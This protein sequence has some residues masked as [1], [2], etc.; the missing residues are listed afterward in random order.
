MI[1][2]FEGLCGV[3]KTTLIEEYAKSR[4]DVKIIPQFIEEPDNLF[5]DCVCMLNDELK[6]KLAID[7]R[8]KVVLM[9]RGYL[10]TLIYG[11]IRY[12]L[13]KQQMRFDHITEWLFNNLNSKLVRPDVYI[14][15]D[16]PNKVCM[17]RVYKDNRMLQE[18]YWYKDLDSVRLWY[19]KLFKTLESGVPLY[20]LNGEHKISSNIK[21]LDKIIHENSI[22]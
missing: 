20:K 18:S 11:L 19:K 5:D 21:L 10:S 12:Q 4:E 8:N 13:T 22:N 15:V 7:N 2:Y 3:G 9:D 1:I 6:S 16:T 17:N 14:W